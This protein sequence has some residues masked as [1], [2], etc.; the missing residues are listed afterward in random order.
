MRGGRKRLSRRPPSSSSTFQ[1]PSSLLSFWQNALITISFLQYLGHVRPA[2]GEPFQQTCPPLILLALTSLV[3]WIVLSLYCL[4]WLP[5]SCLSSCFVWSSSPWYV[6]HRRRQSHS[7][8]PLI[9]SRS[10]ISWYSSLYTIISI[11]IFVIYLLY[12]H[13]FLL[14]HTC[15][16]ICHCSQCTHLVLSPI[17]PVL[18]S[19]FCVS[20]A[21]NISPGMH[22]ISP[23]QWESVPA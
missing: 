12:V 18:Y 20:S 19:S 21:P 11:L 5:L 23:S 8:C 4:L 15:F 7:C 14:T 1:P 6:W 13:F 9:S 2:S 22:C 16:H 10:H 3:I 17:S